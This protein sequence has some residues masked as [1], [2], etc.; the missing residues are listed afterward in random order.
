M[1]APAVQSTN[2]LQLSLRTPVTIAALDT[3][4]SMTLGLQPHSMCQLPFL[5]AFMSERAMLAS[6]NK[7]VLMLQ[8]KCRD[9]I[10]SHSILV[11]FKK[12]TQPACDQLPAIVDALKGAI[13]PTTAAH[14]RR[15]KRRAAAPQMPCE[16]AIAITD[17]PGQ[18][19]STT[20]GHTA[21]R[22]EL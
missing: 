11:P 8:R 15:S 20:P 5:K 3:L 7:W 16:D 18:C 1:R 2:A 13:P 10:I 9:S 21:S 12:W 19:A 14:L 22:S 6:L 17:P 4:T